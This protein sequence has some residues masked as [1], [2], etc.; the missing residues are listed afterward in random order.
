MTR[1][2]NIGFYGHSMAQW[3]RQQE[4]SYITK[5]R[6][7]FDA[8]IVNHGVGMGS[9]ERI[10]FDL[11]KTKH[12]DLVII[13]HS[14]PDFYFVPAENRD[15]CTM[16]RD[17][18]VEK[19]PNGTVKEWFKKLGFE[20][21]P[22]QI[23]DHWEKIPNMP[24][25]EIL[26]D[27]DLAPSYWDDE[28]NSFTKS[29]NKK[30]LFEEWSN[31]GSSDAIKE[32]MKLNKKFASEI[33]YYLGLFDALE[34]MKKYLYHH[35]LQMNRYYG[36]LMQIDQY[37]KFKNIPVVHCL[38]KDY[39]Y[40]KWFKFETGVCDSEIYKL[41]HEITGYYAYAVDS[42][43]NMTEEGNQIAFDMIMPLINQAMEKVNK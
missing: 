18:L 35:D 8:N 9:E 16:D 42:E 41:Q 38:G 23:T 22:E 40:P 10:L 14:N 7:H 13:L 4:F 2:M 5:I 12:L 32:V 29:E 39:W 11:K 1:K 15:F 30:T 27:F 19:V 26:K 17:S 24:C 37:L 28:V 3:S 43:N 36:A 21:V 20:Y 6:D 25:Y 34:L 31:G 33:D